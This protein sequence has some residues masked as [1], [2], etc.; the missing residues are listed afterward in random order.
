MLVCVAVIEQKEF[1]RSSRPRVAEMRI[2]AG[3]PVAVPNS[4]RAGRDRQLPRHE[5]VV[6]D[7]IG[8]KVG[9]IPQREG[10]ERG[11]C[12]LI[13]DLQTNM[14]RVA[15]TSDLRVLLGNAGV[16]CNRAIEKLRGKGGQQFGDRHGN[17]RQVSEEYV[18]EKDMGPRRPRVQRRR[19][20]H[21]QHRDGDQ[22]GEAQATAYPIG[23]VAAN[24]SDE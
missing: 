21:H 8:R 17:Q 5:E 12:R 10:S 6:S 23:R 16:R 18:P 22:C 1:A 13:V 4:N 24:P 11:F 9:Q 14:P 2:D 3:L 15:M 19:K 20:A 7:D